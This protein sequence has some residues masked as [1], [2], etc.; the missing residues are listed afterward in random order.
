MNEVTMPF[1][2]TPVGTLVVF[3]ISLI[4]SH[5]LFIK[6]IPLGKKGWRRI[7][8]VWLLCALFGVVGSAT[9]FQKQLAANLLRMVG[10]LKVETD[11]I[12]RSIK[13]GT[14]DAIC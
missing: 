2:V 12:E 8:Y 9:A 6:V 1:F 7:D 14:S 11:N 3:A 5:I 13:F 10:D 4:V